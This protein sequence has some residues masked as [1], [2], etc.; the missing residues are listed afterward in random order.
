MDTYSI[1]GNTVCA[2]LDSVARVSGPQYR[3]LLTAAGWQ[4]WLTTPPPATWAPVARPT[5]VNRLFTAVYQ[6]LGEDLTRLF[7]TN[8]GNAMA[9]QL[10]ASEAGTELRQALARAPQPAGLAEFLPV[11]ARVQA[12]GW[13][14]ATLHET[15][16]AWLMTVEHCP[17]CSEIRGARA[18]VCA[19]G[20]ALMG[21]MARRLL[22][23]RVRVAEV[24]C[25]ATGDPHCV[26]AF[27]KN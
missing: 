11:F 15:P 12:Q 8:Y 2:M 17:V 13:G 10:L 19:S 9:E 21:Q 3:A 14:N 16:Q 6:M 27:Y 1:P 25:V 20:T 18:P 23:R 22:G 7:F 4:Q 24:A 5:D 26:F